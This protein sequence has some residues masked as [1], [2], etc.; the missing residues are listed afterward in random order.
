[1]KFAPAF[2]AAAAIASFSMG[3]HADTVSFSFNNV[4]ETTEI[5]QT[6]NL[7]LFDGA[8]GT[9]TSVTLSF[10]GENSTSLRLTNNA[11]QA[12][13]VKATTSTDLNF[14]STLGALNSL[15]TA[16]NPI[17]SLSA[18]TGFNLISAGAS[19]TFGPLVDSD[20]LDWTA[21]LS[22]ILGSFVGAAGQNFAVGCTSLSGIA[23]VGGG[24]N[25]GTD[26]QTKAACGAKVVYT[27][28]PTN[29][30]VPEPSALAL[31][32]IALAGAAWARRKA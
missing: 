9:L 19:T 18:T 12:Q 32:G 11:A 2:I 28:T 13:N 30:Q 20:Q 22:G 6:G 15:I 17:V 3:A 26:Q 8:L 16:S 29:T 10:T 31:V 4:L 5:S 14:S 24:G 27:Y 21:Q 1:M 23:L 25:V 7:G